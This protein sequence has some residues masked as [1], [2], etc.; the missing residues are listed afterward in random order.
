MARPTITA[1][2]VSAT[3]TAQLDELLQSPRLRLSSE[4]IAELDAASAFRRVYLHPDAPAW[5]LAWPT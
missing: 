5:L 3:N 2:I 4:Q 1:P